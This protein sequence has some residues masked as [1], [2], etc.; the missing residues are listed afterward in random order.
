M[1]VLTG[2]TL[3]APAGINAY[4]P[5][6]TVAIAQALGWVHLRQ[7]FDLLGSWWAIAIIAVLLVVEI[8]ADKVPAVDHANDAIQTV[9]RP[10]AGGILALAASGQAG[11]S[12]VLMVVAGVLI[13]GGVH[14]VKAA[15]RPVINASTV[16]TGA[17]VVSTVED[18]GAA[19]MTV[20]ALIAPWLAAAVIVGAIVLVGFAIRRWRR[21]RAERKLQRAH[22]ASSEAPSRD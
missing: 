1:D 8:V 3:A 15:A 2:L 19:F 9:L 18:I 6:L 17:P 12:P 22:E 20:L 21:K 4:I 13:A 5:L 14:T 10:A 11:V 16:G 7:P